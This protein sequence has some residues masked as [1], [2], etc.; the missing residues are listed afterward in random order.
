MSMLFV[1]KNVLQ[2]AHS[3]VTAAAGLLRK[4]ST[5]ELVWIIPI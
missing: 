5:F 3:F 2:P 1:V 4:K